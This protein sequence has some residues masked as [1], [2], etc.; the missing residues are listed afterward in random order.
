MNTMYVYWGGLDSG[1]AHL[2]QYAM[3][4]DKTVLL[5]STNGKQIVK[6]YNTVHYHIPINDLLDFNPKILPEKSEVFSRT[7]PY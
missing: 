3:S 4:N 1:K 6:V 2:R 5:W 7:P